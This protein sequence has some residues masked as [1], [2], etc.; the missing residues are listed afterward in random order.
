MRKDLTSSRNRD[1]ELARYRQ[2]GN[3]LRSQLAEAL[4]AVP[5]QR[6]SP[7]EMSRW[8]GVHRSVC[9]WVRAAA[10]HTGDPALALER[11][12]GIEGLEKLL[13]ALRR[14]GVEPRRVDGALA[15][16]E[17][18]REAI[19]LAGGSRA[20]LIRDVAMLLHDEQ[21]AGNGDPAVRGR[22]RMFEAAA[23]VCGARSDGLM[24]IIVATP[25]DGAELRCVAVMGQVN[26]MRE[27]DHLPLVLSRRR[28]A[29]PGRS[30]LTIDGDPTDGFTPGAVIGR[31]SSLPL[32]TVTST[33]RDQT[34]VQVL[35]AGGESPNPL[36][37][38]VGQRFAVMPTRSGGS[39]ELVFSA[40]PRVPT[41][42]LVIDAYLHKD[43]RALE[44]PTG[45]AQLLGGD[46][47][48]GPE[49]RWYDQIGSDLPVHVID[50]EACGNPTYARHAELAE[51]LIEQSGQ[52]REDLRAWRLEVEFPV[53][54]TRYHLRFALADTADLGA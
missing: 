50:R 53:W 32:P 2:L 24:V 43:V 35:D 47:S 17:L 34:L 31:F 46:G 33:A 49:R 16:L 26:V 14:R 45:F 29:P 36:T 27:R 23:E 30:E 7:T 15:G 48:A 20:K 54:S 39:G 13:R 4:D 22:E 51:W 9:H 1:R 6:R 42:R 21:T 10:T 44:S 38:F 3:R 8:L 41:R 28:T 11:L 40:V 18:Y 52:A 19:G 37:A 25:G 5:P 12:P